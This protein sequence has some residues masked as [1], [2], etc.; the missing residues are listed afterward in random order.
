[1]GIWWFSVSIFSKLARTI[2][3]KR[4]IIHYSTSS[5]Q[6]HDSSSPKNPLKSPK[7]YR[8]VISMWISR[9]IKVTWG[10]WPLL[11]SQWPIANRHMFCGVSWGAESEFVVH[12]SQNVPNHFFPRSFDHFEFWPL[13]RSQPARVMLLYLGALHMLNVAMGYSHTPI[14]FR[15]ERGTRWWMFQIAT[16]HTYGAMSLY[17]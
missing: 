11:T 10:H 8:S 5:F 3:L 13:R 2:T 4:Y 12:C 14:L 9:S 1:M 7:N 15:I 6:Q 17:S 16:T